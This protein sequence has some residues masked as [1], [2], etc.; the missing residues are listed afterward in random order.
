M[1][2]YPRRILIAF[3]LAVLGGTL[4]HFAYDFFP[5]AVTAVFAPVSE[6]IWEHLKLI[7]W[8]YL[9]AFFFLA[10]KEPKSFPAAWLFSLLLIS[11]LLLGAGYVYHILCG[12]EALF[13]D[14]ALYVLLMATGFFLPRLLGKVSWSGWL[15]AFLWIA[16]IAL[17]FVLLVFTWYPPRGLLFVDLSAVRTWLTIPY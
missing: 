1:R 11:A 4:L 9:I 17:G 16:V 8:P 2:V 10:R 7:Y 6:S 13:F 3:V 14:I 5:N 12:G 15:T